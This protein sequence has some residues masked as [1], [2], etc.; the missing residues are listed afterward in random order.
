MNASDSM[1]KIYILQVLQLVLS[2]SDSSRILICK[3]ASQ[4]SAVTKCLV[5]TCKTSGSDLLLVAQTLD[6]FYDIFSE[7]YYNQFLQE[8]NVIL[9]MK[10]GQAHL[11][12]LYVQAMQQKSLS[13]GELAT[14]DNALTNLPAFITYKL[15]E[16]K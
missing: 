3:D 1:A 16:M 13:K 11:N 15:T 9:L 2:T 14:V 12:Q 5:D 7:A 4:M 10:E 6:T 8:H